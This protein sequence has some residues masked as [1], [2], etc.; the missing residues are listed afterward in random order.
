MPFAPTLGAVPHLPE[1]RYINY[2]LST[3]NYQLTE[4]EADR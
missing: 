4:G 1:K 2:Q 3:I